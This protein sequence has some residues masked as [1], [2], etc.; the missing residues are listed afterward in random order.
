MKKLFPILA[1]ALMIFAVAS[2]GEKDPNDGPD[3][4]TPGGN[5]PTVT[6][7]QANIDVTG[8]DGEYLAVVDNSAKTVKISLEYADK[9]NAKAL[10]V[11]FIGLPEGVTAEYQ[12]TFNYSD[13]ATQ[14][15]AFKYEGETVTEYVVS[16]AIGQ[17]DPQFVSLTVGGVNA[18]GGEVRLSNTTPLSAIPVEFVVTPA[19][20]KVSVAGAEIASGAEVDFSDKVNGVTFTLTCGEVTKTLTVK[21]VTAGIAKVER[22]WAHY[23][24]PTTIEDDWYATQTRG[25][26]GNWQRTAAMDAN[27]VY[28]A[29]HGNA[30]KEGAWE[31][32]YVL[33]VADGSLV[34]T[35]STNGINGGTHA[36][37]A[38]RTIPDGDGGYKILD[39][40]LAIG[41]VLKVYMWNDKDSDPVTVLSY[42]NTDGLRLGDKM[43]VS[44][45]WKDGE[46]AFLPNAGNPRKLYKFAIK[47]GKVN[48]VPTVLELPGFDAGTY[49][50]AYK[51]S[52][53]EILAVAAGTRP[54]AYSVNGT[55]CTK[56]LDFSSEVFSATDEGFN[57]FTFN[58]QQYMAFTR[59]TGDLCDASLRII[60]I[61]GETLADAVPAI[62]G[63]S[64]FT[65]GLGDPTEHPITGFKS[66]NSLGDCTVRV[67]G[68]ETY[69][70][71]ISEG[72]GVSLFKLQ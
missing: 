44:G 17:P 56:T 69:I 67:I 29:Q 30:P 19:D 70:L 71:A 2:C 23:V 53:T 61:D 36:V 41:G 55:T 51:Y 47:D 21:V 6:L 42:E 52:D 15:V 57:F 24:Q 40:N 38:I 22:V 34:G 7:S 63:S 54:F 28:I 20:T 39:C 43:S 48:S 10:T 72:A 9:E 16:V 26:A 18:L 65:Y 4:P 68:G 14:T 3:T 64:F 27:Y 32:A 5:A 1:S 35:L 50:E 60:A 33:S 49:G 11:S 12:R 8:I 13:G 66:G 62:N 37:S 25:I 46:L 45:T 58:D 31:A 59:L